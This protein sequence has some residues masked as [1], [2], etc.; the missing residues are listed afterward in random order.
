MLAVKGVMILPGV[1]CQSIAP[2]EKPTRSEEELFLSAIADMS[3]GPEGFGLRRSGKGRRP[4]T[5]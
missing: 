2:D 1:G 5:G 3:A 4:W